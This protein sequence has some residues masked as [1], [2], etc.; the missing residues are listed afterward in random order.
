MSVTPASA[1]I[2]TVGVDT[3]QFNFN[4]CNISG[5]A[6]FVGLT[7]HKNDVHFGGTNSEIWF[8]GN[9]N[10]SQ[11]HMVWKS[12]VA[13]GKGGLYIPSSNI[14]FGGSK[15]Q[16]EPHGSPGGASSH[17]KIKQY[18]SASQ[19]NPLRIES[20]Y[21][22]FT[23]SPGNTGRDIARFEYAE[24]ASLYYT[25]TKRLQTS[26]VGVTVTGSLDVSEIRDNAL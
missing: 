26:G 24:G 21:T 5:I 7:T 22:Y 12:G 4:R 20:D 10:H 3:S 8:W 19:L 18:S 23:G 2:V 11:N 17:F 15:T 25:G 9:V 6:T 13:G 14:Y 1:G 16:F